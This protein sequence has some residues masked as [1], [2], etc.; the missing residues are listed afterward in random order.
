MWKCVLICISAASSVFFACSNIGS[1]AESEGKDKTL[2]SLMAE[3]RIDWENELEP[4]ALKRNIEKLDGVESGV[5]ITPQ[6]YALSALKRG[7]TVYP[8]IEGFGSLDTSSLT[9]EAK[10]VLDGFCN[11]FLDGSGEES[12]IDAEKKYALVFFLSDIKLFFKT[13]KNI[14]DGRTYGTPFIKDETFGVPVRFTGKDV[15]LDVFIYLNRN[16]DWKI[17]QIQIKNIRTAENAE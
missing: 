3:R 9:K 7:S 5:D 8:F 4:I 17:N 12:Y 13:E 16:S 14:F 15:L 11:A 2:M 6:T 1:P 10:A